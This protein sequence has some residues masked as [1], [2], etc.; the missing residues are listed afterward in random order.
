MKASSQARKKIMITS[1]KYAQ[2]TGH[3]SDDDEGSGD[4]R[5]D[6]ERSQPAVLARRQGERRG[7]G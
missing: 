1:L 2:Q 6:Q 5:Q 7:G 4:G 3:E